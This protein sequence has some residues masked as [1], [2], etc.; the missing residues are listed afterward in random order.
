MIFFCLATY[1]SASVTR[2]HHGS[3]RRISRAGWNAAP[4][5]KCR[6]L[7]LAFVLCPAIAFGLLISGH[8]QA[9]TIVQF[10]T[11]L[12]NFEVDLYDNAA[13]LTVANFLSYVSSGAYADSLIHR[14]V[15]GFIVQ[16]GGYDENGNT[17]T[18][19]GTVQNEFLNSNLRGTIAMAKLASGPNTA[20]T[21]WFFNLADNSSNLDN[22]N[23]GFTVFGRVLGDGMTTVDAIAA[24]PTFAFASPFDQVPLQN[25]TQAQFTAG[26]APGANNLI[27]VSSIT[28]V[29]S[30]APVWQNPLNRF[31]V[32]GNNLIE[33]LDALLI[34]N[35][36]NSGGARALSSTFAG[37]FYYDVDGDDYLSFNDAQTVLGM[38]DQS[39][40]MANAVL[41]VPEPSTIA[42]AAIGLAVL[43]R[44]GLRTRSRWVGSA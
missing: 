6:R 27:V 32:A 18:A 24:L 35:A 4:G 44:S 12:G 2:A 37:P 9:N 36:V 28:D 21:Q 5:P 19:N 14:S 40:A 41:A 8:L 25:F 34:I 29:G 15:P 3:R 39:P 13:P 23:G 43:L 22:Q 16:G 38:L 20:S 10:D 33:P 26:N 11:S 1:G 7:W 30:Y 17:I 31:D 42:L